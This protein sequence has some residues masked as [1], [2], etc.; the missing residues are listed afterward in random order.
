MGRYELPES[1]GQFPE[2]IL[3]LIA[4]AI[5][6]GVFVAFRDILREGGLLAL[7]GIG[8]NFFGLY[9]MFS[10]MAEEKKVL[11]FVI[12][13]ALSFV[14]VACCRFDGHRV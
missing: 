9:L 14:G 5:V 12:C 4:G 6:V 1:S 7:L 2:L 3:W 10:F 8:L 11:G 13:L